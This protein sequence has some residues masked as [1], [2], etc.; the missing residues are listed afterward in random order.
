MRTGAA[1]T[2]RGYFHEAVCYPSEEDLL[3]V[4]VPFVRG[5][6]AA[7]EPTVVSFGEEHAALV[8]RALPDQDGVTF[9]SGGPLY[10]RPASAIRAYREMLAA[11]VAAGAHQIRII[12]ELPLDALGNTWDAW[13]RYESAINHAY[14]DFPLWSM[15]AYDTR[16]TPPTVLDEVAQTHPRHA[17]PGD[18]HVGSD[19]YVE[20]E[21]FLREL[22]APVPDPVQAGR[23]IV[24][25]EDPSPAAARR[26][27]VDAGQGVLAAGELADLVLAV[28]EVVTNGL[29]HGVGPVRLRMWVGDDRIIVEIHDGGS[30]PDDPYAGLLPAGTGL[31]GGLGL[32][33]THQLCNHVTLTRGDGGFSVRLTAGNPHERPEP[34]RPV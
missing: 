1:A 33:L 17:L 23:P 25:L 22:R 16:V 18:R 19:S 13:A 28:S 31:G 5:G 4:V 10:A 15:C 29:R 3:A 27:V 8:R 26:A 20:P 14:D 11:Y 34:D 12:G 9:L 6:V 2:H 32:W 24:E 21:E 7:G 30:G